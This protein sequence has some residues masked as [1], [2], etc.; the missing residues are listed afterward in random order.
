MSMM[1]QAAPN[2]ARS[3]HS[4]SLDS[5]IK[6]KRRGS[7]SGKI[8]ASTS[9]PI[10]VLETATSSTTL[11]GLH[12]KD[13]SHR[14]NESTPSPSIERSTTNQRTSR[15]QTS[16]TRAKPST[17]TS[18]LISSPINSRLCTQYALLKLCNRLTRRNSRH[19]S[20]IKPI[21]E[22]GLKI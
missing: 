12:K 5:T 4:S 20:P 15:S 9:T 1:P 6:E 18:N 11:D 14:T 2:A 8:G 22:A 7:Y 21:S 10:I 13:N 3:P 19:T 17:T 16:P